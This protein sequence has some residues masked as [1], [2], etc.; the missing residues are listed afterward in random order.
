MNRKRLEHGVKVLQELLARRVRD[1][2]TAREKEGDRFNILNW[3]YTTSCGTSACVAGW[4]TLDPVFQAQG[5]SNSREMGLGVLLKPRYAGLET[6]RALEKFFDIDTLQAW[7]IFDANHTNRI[8]HAIERIQDVLAGADAY[9]MTYT[10]K[11]Q[12]EEA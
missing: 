3:G 10:R 9:S 12:A 6:Y 2:D 4:F 8:D 7:H 5:L 1:G 11:S